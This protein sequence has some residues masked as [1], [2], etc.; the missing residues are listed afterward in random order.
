M[1]E[2]IGR[3]PPIDLALA[4]AVMVAGLVALVTGRRGGRFRGLPAWAGFWVIF[5]GI[6]ICLSRADRWISFPVLAVLMFFALRAYFYLA[7]VRPQDRYAILATY[8]AIP[9]ALYPAFIGSTATFLATVPVS[10]FLFIPVFLAVARAEKGMLDSMGRTLLG[11]VFFVYCTAHLTLL[12]N[13]PNGQGLLELFGILV[14]ASELPQRVAGRL[15]RRSRW[16][17][18]T[19]GVV[20]GFLLAVGLGFW[21]G[22][23]CGLVEEDGGRAGAL[24]SIAVTLGAL[25]SNAVAEDLELSSSSRLGRGAMLDRMAPAFYAAPVFFHYI[26]HFA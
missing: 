24:V 2:L 9:L 19:V 25:I 3:I 12:P 16:V 22:P 8:L 1:D 15:G 18:S 7:P 23:W 10:L 20:I 6:L 17:R 4:V 14:L 5:A 21:L 13:H 11:V 26:D